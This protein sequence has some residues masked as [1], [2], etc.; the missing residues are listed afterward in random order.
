MASRKSPKGGTSRNVAEEFPGVSAYKDRHGTYRWRFRLNGKTINLGK[1]Y[2]SPEFIRRYQAAV[3]GEPIRH[4]REAAR[5]IS[6]AP[7]GSLSSVIASWYQSP[8]YKRLGASTRT[9][10]RRIAEKLREEH[11]EKPVDALTRAN[12]KTLMAQKADTPEAANALLRILR[13]VLDHAMED[14]EMLET[15]P[16]RAVRKYAPKN[17]DGYHTWSE[18]EIARYF[19]RW[20]EGTPA[21]LAMALMLYTGAAR[22]D[23]VQLG[24][25]NLVNGRVQYRRQ[26]MKTRNGV[27]V[28][29]PLH[30]ELA[31]RLDRLPEGQDTFL[32]TE[33]G[34]P[35][36]AAGL[37]NAMRKWTRAA[38]LEECTAHGL[39]KACA[40][41]LAEA[42]A[43]PH[44][45][46]AVTGH[47]TLA[48]V[49]R[50]TSKVTRAGLADR[51]F[52]LT[53]G[54]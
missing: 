24:P 35:R 40:R 28:D 11:G 12:V 45:I 54:G 15:N 38:G 10:Y 18:G 43:T 13:L 8:E 41:R 30:P 36:S 14:L 17:P 39:R 20:E 37:G 6:Q 7:P 25:H 4:T 48:E 9:N 31:R 21:D 49:E 44:E 19:E 50:Y 52:K 53:D 42:G 46:M 5:R 26:K 32:Q 34:K 2:G 23:A 16:A 3:K 33:Y 1:E 47:Q 27:L 51:A 22:A 29:I